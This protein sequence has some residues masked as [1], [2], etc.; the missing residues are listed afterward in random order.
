MKKKNLK[1]TLIVCD[2]NKGGVGKSLLATTITSLLMMDEHSVTLIEADQTNPDVAR[3]FNGYAPILL[4]DLSDKDGWFSLLDELESIKTEYIVMSLPAGLNEVE[5]IQSLLQRTLSC[6]GIELKHVF[7]LSR[8]VDSVSLLEKSLNKG[9]A[10]FAQTSI[11][12]KNGFFGR[13]EQ[14]DR[15]RDS[16]LRELWIK[17]GFTDSF[18][19]ELNHRL[20]DLLELNP[21]PLH[22]LREASLSTALRIDL[23]DWLNS[24]QVSLSTI[25]KTDHSNGGVS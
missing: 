21:L 15:W 8:Q 19:D 5:A 4:A 2:G 17:K 13:D 18:L 14:F 20:I 11:A 7:C 16:K 9:L 24:A 6:L 10:S 3:R 22:L 12:I 1:Q 25:V 23:E